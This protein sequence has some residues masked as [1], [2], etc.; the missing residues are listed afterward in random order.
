M[1]QH[2]EKLVQ[3]IQSTKDEHPEMSC[4]VIEQD[5]QADRGPDLVCD[6]PPERAKL[7]KAGH[8]RRPHGDSCIHHFPA[9]FF[10]L[11]DLCMTSVSRRT[12]YDVFPGLFLKIAHH[13]IRSYIASEHIRPRVDKSEAGAC[14]AFLG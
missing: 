6:Y 8:K 2:S 5:V 10:A 11:V 1:K 7:R 9:F 13:Q 12:R 14:R 3:T 4:L